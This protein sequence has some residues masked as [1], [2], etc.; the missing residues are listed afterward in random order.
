M[1]LSLTIVDVNTKLDMVGT[2][3]YVQKY[4]SVVLVLYEL[5]IFE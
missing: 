3:K 5:D 4:S 2:Y 1:K